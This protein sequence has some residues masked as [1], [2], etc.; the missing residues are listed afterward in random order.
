MIY[1]NM[2]NF[3]DNLLKRGGNGVPGMTP[4]MPGGNAPIGASSATGVAGSAFKVGGRGRR[5]RTG[6]KRRSRGGEEAAGGRR[7]RKSKRSS[8]S[9]RR[10][11]SRRSRR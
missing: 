4:G 2:A 11:R 9:K 8:S 3:M 10:S 5:R 1:I 7:R 6:S